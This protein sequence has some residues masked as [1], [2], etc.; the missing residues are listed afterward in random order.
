M[1]WAPL[2]VLGS[3]LAG[4]LIGERFGPSAAVGVIVA[5]LSVGVI[6]ALLR[7]SPTR[8]V[9]AL[10]AVVL[11]G[12]ALTQRAEHGRVQWPLAEAVVERA[13]G[14]ITA[15]LVDDPD[16]TRFTT[17]ALVRIERGRLVD[18]ESRDAGWRDAGG[19]TVLVTATDDAAPRLA[20][21]D[22]GDRVTLRGW[23]R[24][25]DGF[26]ERSR[27]RHAVAEFA[28]TGFLDFEAPGATHMR[29]ANTIRS[30]VLRG[31]DALPPTERALMA[32]FLLGDTRAIP[33]DVL[34][35]FRSSGL[36][37][38]L[39]VSGANVAFVLALVGPALRRFPRG[40]RLVGTLTVL[41][42]F[43]FMTRWEPSVMRAS[44]MAAC[45]VVAVHLGRPA[46]TIRV[47][48]VA[49][50]TLLVID[51]FLV[52]S[53]GFQL[54]CGAS[55]G[56]ALFSAPI[57]RRMRGPEW[58]RASFSTTAAAQLGVAPVLLPV[59]G[60][61]PLVT[62]PANLLA[63]PLVGPLTLWGLGAGAVGGLIGRGATELAAGLQ[64]PTR[65]MAE[66]VIGIADA[67]ARV[68]F[69]IDLRA[70]VVLGVVVGVTALARHRR[71]LRR[72]ALVVPPR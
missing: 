19:R 28:A 66:A 18:P 22:A 56:I 2:A 69:A 54:S 34:E 40:A 12:C 45:A 7:R 1:S 48:T 51:P 37:H 36:T 25:L 16:G 68:P 63:V 58:L 55:L 9:L 41:A 39:A 10:L 20:L 5:G 71:M 72:D 23:F 38:L 35:S 33:D 59:F 31:N 57:A 43:G 53:V 11:T 3:L 17:N 50:T 64:L 29:V 13:D 61:M 44:A 62:L 15:S 65:V 21:L 24:P 30:V 70:G 6:A 27:W 52:H 4:I 32:G 26:D 42:L 46:R 67:A 14:T 47:L 60:S 49:V 8:S